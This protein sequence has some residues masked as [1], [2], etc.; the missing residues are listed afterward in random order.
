MAGEDRG[1]LL[2]FNDVTSRG[3]VVGQRG[4]RDLDHGSSGSML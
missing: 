1:A 2:Q 4:Q 3:N